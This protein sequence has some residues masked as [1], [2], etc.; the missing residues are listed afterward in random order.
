MSVLV[1]LDFDGVVSPYDPC[2]PAGADWRQFRIGGFDVRIRVQVLDFLHW[3]DASP[4]VVAWTSSW[5]ALTQGFS[6]DTSGRI[7]EFPFLPLRS[8]RRAK[9]DAIEAAANGMP[10]DY[11]PGALPRVGPFDLVIVADDHRRVGASVKRRLGVRAVT[12]TPRDHVGLTN[13][14][15]ATIRRLISSGTMGA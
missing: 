12:V 2:E 8:G 10:W 9:R 7:P 13:R 11:P 14:Q 4:T 5:D 6:A 1:T 15:V 3:L